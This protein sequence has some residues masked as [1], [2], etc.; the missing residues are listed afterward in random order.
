MLNQ[1]FSCKKKKD[2]QKTNQ[3]DRG[4][5][6]DRYQREETSEV[7]DIIT[8]FDCIMDTNCKDYSDEC[9]TAVD[10]K[11]RSTDTQ[12]YL[13]SEKKQP[14]CNGLPPIRTQ[15]LP[16]IT[17][18]NSFLTSSQS[19]TSSVSLGTNAYHFAHRSQKSRSEHDLLDHRSSCQ[20]L[21]DNPWNTDANQI[22]SY[23][24]CT[25]TSSDKLIDDLLSERSSHVLLCPPHLPYLPSSPSGN[26]FVQYPPYHLISVDMAG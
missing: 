4:R 20:T 6:R 11:R 19:A 22:L 23:K 18:G 25:A 24:V 5:D 16:P 3:K 13:I 10:F 1:I 21:S 7:D 9:M 15:S 26:F 14:E 12:K 2:D 8:T 17:I